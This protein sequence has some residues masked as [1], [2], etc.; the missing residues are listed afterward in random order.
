MNHN[1]SDSLLNDL[2]SQNRLRQLFEIQLLNLDITET[3]AL[4]IMQIERRAL[5]GILDGT[6]K[7]IDYTTLP[8]LAKFLEIP[9]E[10]VV[11]LYV[12]QL[13][14]NFSD[15]VAESNKRKFMAENFDLPTLRKIGFIESI[16]DYVHIEKTIVEYFGYES[17]F[18]YRKNRVNV[19]YSQGGPK[20][21]NKLNRDLWIESAFTKLQK[22]NNYYP[23]NRD[24]LLEF[25]PRI[26]WY[27]TNEAK[28]LYQ[29]VREL[30]KLGVTVIFESYL[31]TMYVR[32]AAF[33]VN[34]KPC[35]ALTNYTKYY[36]SLWFGLI[37]EL[38]HVLYDWDDLEANTYMVSG[39]N[40]LF[41]KGEVEADE[42]AR[43]FLLPKDQM[44]YLEPHIN[45]EA[46]IYE[47]SKNNHI[48]HSF[49][50][51]FYS[52]DHKDLDKKVWGRYQK[53][54]PDI[55]ETL[56]ALAANPWQKKKSIKDTVK[57]IKSDLFNDL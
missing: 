43:E 16:T 56:K 11:N 33:A 45:N 14:I 5:N 31:P 9:I 27:S 38:H 1:Y 50:Y 24:K 26:R 2:F 20:P 6:Q 48:H 55:S 8:K 13:Q 57:Q 51:I 21:K 10:E 35:I 44:D 39:E 4:E 32:G 34:H 41:A 36:P 52:W 25:F 23:Y 37:H 3:A 7:R 54:I 17:I 53:H 47:Y 22:I 29:V 40:D 12:Q 18:D 15:D 42:F 19:A 49:F 30:F 46:F 28:G